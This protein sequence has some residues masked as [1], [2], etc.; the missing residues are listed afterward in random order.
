LNG[1]IYQAPDL[2]TN[3]QSRLVGAVEPLKK[4]LQQTLEMSRFN[5]TK[6]YYWDFKTEPAKQTKPMDEEGDQ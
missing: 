2:Y 6:G 3:I 4:A 5:V 1:I